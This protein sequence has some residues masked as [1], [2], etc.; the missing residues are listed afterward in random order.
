MFAYPSLYEG[1]GLPPLEAMSAG[2]PVV[3]TRTGGITEVVEDAAVVV[4]PGD[5]DALADGLA[6]VLADDG[7]ADDLR[8]RGTA[9]LARFSWD[10]TAT[11]LG[12]L[13]HRLAGLLVV[14]ASGRVPSPFRMPRV[15]ALVTG[16]AGFVGRHLVSHLEA[17]GD[18]VTGIDREHGI[19]LLDPPAHDR[20][21]RGRAARR[22]LPPR[23]VERCRRIVGRAAGRL[24]RQR[25]GHAQR[26]R[27]LPRGR[28]APRAAGQQRR[29]LRQG[30]A[31]RASAHRGV[32][33]S[34]GDARTPPARSPPTN[35]G[36]RRGSATDSRCCACGRST[37]SARVRRTASCVPALAERIALNEIE[38]REVVTVGNLTPR[39][40][41]TDVRDVVRALPA[42]RRERRAGRGLQRVLGSRHRDRR[43]RRSAHHHGRPSR[44]VSKATR[45]C[46]DPSTCPCSGAT[47][48]SSRKPPAGTPRSRSIKPCSTCSTSGAN[49]VG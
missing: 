8:A 25:R 3:T 40:D 9:N 16:V 6:K 26:A 10:R 46:S 32:T 42:P 43:A 38:G 5:T 11:E 23:R 22:G 2:V 28:R 14:P 18:V 44:C 49:S 19:D 20:R 47:T 39:R 31:R 37:I 35:W 29:R 24:P 27:G 34:T 30:L 15:K 33:L 4:P 7:L 36:C 12:A 21:R 48:R 1:F 17:S 13:Y 41:F 45:V